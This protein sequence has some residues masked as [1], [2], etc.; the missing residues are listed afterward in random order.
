MTKLAIG[1]SEQLL[2]A[3]GM[4]FSLHLERK[5][6]ICIFRLKTRIASMPETICLTLPKLMS[7][8]KESAIRH[9]HTL[10]HLRK[11]NDLRLQFRAVRTV[12]MFTITRTKKYAYIIISSFGIFFFDMF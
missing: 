4:Y 5:E 1:D 9:F 11:L 12:R 8:T 6:E 7:L 10:V 3:I 2:W